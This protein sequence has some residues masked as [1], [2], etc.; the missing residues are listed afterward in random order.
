[1]GPGPVGIAYAVAASGGGGTTP[2]ETNLYAYLSM[3]ETGSTSALVDATGNSRNFSK[4]AGGDIA[5]IPGIIGNGID[6]TNNQWRADTGVFNMTNHSFSMRF[7]FK[8]G[9]VPGT[10]QNIIR[11]PSSYEFDLY[12]DGTIGWD[13]GEYVY[14]DDPH[15]L[16]TWHRA[17]VWFNNSTGDIG[18]K[19][20]DATSIT[21]GSATCNTGTY[22]YINGWDGTTTLGLDEIAIWKDYV[23]TEDDMTYDWNSGSGRGKP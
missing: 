4:Y 1:M 14:T 23:L 16:N 12:N 18:L 7:W 6:V 13:L 5:S 21:T 11:L 20:D 3:E 8:C 17:V 10:T 22:L 19:L 9:G 2:Y 15:S